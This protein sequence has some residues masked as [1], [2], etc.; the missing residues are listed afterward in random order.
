MTEENKKCPMCNSDMGITR[1]IPSNYKCVKCGHEIPRNSTA[2]KTKRVCPNCESE[3]IEFTGYSYY[4][5]AEMKEH[6]QIRCKSC[7]CVFDDSEIVIKKVVEEVK[8]ETKIT[9][10]DIVSKFVLTTEVEVRDEQSSY[11]GSVSTLLNSN[12]YMLGKEVKSC[13]LIYNLPDDESP[14]IPGAYL[15]IELK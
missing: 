11:F 8:E 15:K 9:L 6:H 12:L 2:V 3:D 5:H 14:E 13:E 1:G 10:K 4:D 7:R